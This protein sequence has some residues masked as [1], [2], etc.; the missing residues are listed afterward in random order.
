MVVYTDSP[1]IRESRKIIIELLLA[2]APD[3]PQLAEFAKEYGVTS[4][5]VIRFA[6]ITLRRC[7][8]GLR[9]FHESKA[10]G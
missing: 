7:R 5:G 4:T 10:D 1:G 9:R 6:E 2:Q 3:S 8:L